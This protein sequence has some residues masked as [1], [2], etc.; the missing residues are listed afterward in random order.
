MTGN[1]IQNK[2]MEMVIKKTSKK[3][4]GENMKRY[5]F[6][7]ILGLSVGGCAYLSKPIT[8]PYGTLPADK[9]KQLYDCGQ[10]A[11]LTSGGNPLIEADRSRN[12]LMMKYGWS[13]KE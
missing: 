8:P 4:K 10:D 5:A 1:K 9:Q 11:R 3:E 7:L 6:I 13:V 2:K 12:C